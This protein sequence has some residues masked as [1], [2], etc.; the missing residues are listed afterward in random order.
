MSKE[1]PTYERR[2]I[3][4]ETLT[5]DQQ[6]ILA[7]VNRF[8]G[9]LPGNYDEIP[10][11]DFGGGAEMKAAVKQILEG[12]KVNEATEVTEVSKLVEKQLSGAID[13]VQTKLI[14]PDM[15]LVQ[16]P[17]LELV[18]KLMNLTPEQ[19]QVILKMQDPRL[20]F[21]LEDM[22]FANYVEAINTNKKRGQID[23]YVDSDL[24]WGKRPVQQEGQVIWTPSIGESAQEIEENPWAGQRLGNQVAQWDQSRPDWLQSQG[25]E[26]YS[27]RQLRAIEGGNPL[28]QR[29]WSILR[30][31]TQQEWVPGGDWAYG[32]VYFGG[33]FQCDH[34]RNA[35]F[36]AEVVGVKST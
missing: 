28:D 18:M 10:N 34:R 2:L 32:Q 35:R 24:G 27:I 26:S 25:R 21:A 17:T 1:Q 31:P 36:R 15:E 8:K 6:A 11:V 22:P 19:A 4:R 9:Q 3:D 30:D 23:T 14:K 13:L 12:V 7:A 5:A 16:K 20:E 29:N 33:Y